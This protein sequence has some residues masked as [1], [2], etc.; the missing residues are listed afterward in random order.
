MAR[1][2]NVFRDPA[3]NLPDYPWPINHS[4]EEEGGR[5]RNIETTALTSGVGLVMQQGADSLP[6]L[7]YSGTILTEA[8]LVAMRSWYELCRTQTI[9]FRDFA[10]DEAEV[11]V[12]A[13]KPT[14]KRTMRNARDLVNAPLHYWTYS[15]EMTVIRVISGAIA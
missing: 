15:L 11:I 10:G 13:F 1:T 3:G 2:P 9:I 4:E 7:R 6:T 5:V 8:Q 14:R 12:T